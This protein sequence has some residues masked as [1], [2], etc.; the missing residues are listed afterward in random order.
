M[1]KYLYIAWVTLFIC[2]LVS[3]YFFFVHDSS[4]NEFL[5]NTREGGIF[6]F[7]IMALQNVETGGV[8]LI[9][10]GNDGEMH[11]C[12]NLQYESTIKNEGEVIELNIWD[13]KDTEICA[14]SLWPAWIS[15][16]LWVEVASWKTYTLKLWFLWDVDT[17]KVSIFSDKIKI[18]SIRS[19]F[20]KI[21][22]NTIYFINKD[23]LHIQCFY[24]GTWY[25]NPFDDNCKELFARLSERFPEFIKSEKNNPGLVQ[26][27]GIYT[28]SNSQRLDEYM[29]ALFEQFSATGYYLNW[30][31]QNKTYSKHFCE[32]SDGDFVSM[33][34]MTSKQEC[35]LEQGRMCEYKNM[36]HVGKSFI[37]TNHFPFDT[38]NLKLE[39]EKVPV[40]IEECNNERI[41]STCITE[42]AIRH[43]DESICEKLRQDPD[44]GS[45]VTEAL[46]KKYVGWEF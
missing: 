27:S 35:S 18:D 31:F 13:I 39:Y 3:S 14:T 17:Y 20:S 29:D 7:E 9:L 15:W 33:D 28:V 5:T 16:E 44:K 30:S 46:C 36:G 42:F 32:C 19:R 26:K 41:I 38:T 4:E 23:L 8:S 6:S 40:S 22:N 37:I 12:S 34:F 1:K 43:K 10:T 25:E 11:S 2:L 24:N 45:Y 21:E